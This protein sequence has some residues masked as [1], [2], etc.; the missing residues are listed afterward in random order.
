[1]CSRPG[2]GLDGIAGKSI[3]PVVERH[4]PIVQCPDQT[5]IAELAMNPDGITAEHEF[6]RTS[7]W[8]HVSHCSPCYAQFL[9]LRK[10][11][12]QRGEKQRTLLRRLAVTTAAAV[13]VCLGLLALQ[14]SGKL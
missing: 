5:A 4:S 9:H 1:V 6:D 7:V 10:L 3:L 11:A 2:N 14:L 12:R 8:F 13:V